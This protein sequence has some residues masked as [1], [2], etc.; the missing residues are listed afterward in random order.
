MSHTAVLVLPEQDEKRARKFAAIITAA[1]ATTLLLLFIFLKLITPIPA[2]PPDPEVVAVE[3][4]LDDGFGG[5][6]A[7][8]LGGGSMGNTNTPGASLPTGG[9]PDPTPLQPTPSNGAITSPDPS[10]PQTTSGDPQP[11]SAVLAAIANYNKN[12]G[13][14]SVSVGGQGSDPSGYGVNGAGPGPGGPG[15]GDPGQGGPGGGNSKCVRKISSKPTIINPTQE[16]GIVQV[17]VTVDR[18]G[19]V[20]K[21]EVNIKGTTTTNSILRST[22]TQSAY[23]IKFNED[24]TCSE[25]VEFPIDINFTLK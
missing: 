19:N 5:D 23:K 10:N 13:T 21:A 7:A 2:I 1:I 15:G 24:P 20:T 14:A 9:T 16:E 6:N 22:A 3:I 25:L 8:T 17:M 4:G 12:K 11:S 18:N